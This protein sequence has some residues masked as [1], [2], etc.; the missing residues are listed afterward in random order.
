[1]GLT[2]QPCLVVLKSWSLNFPETPEPVQAYT[3]A[4]LSCDLTKKHSEI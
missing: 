2:L 3:E 4:V 1:V